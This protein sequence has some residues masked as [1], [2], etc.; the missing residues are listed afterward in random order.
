M[1]L[2]SHNVETITETVFVPVPSYGS[3]G[4]LWDNAGYL[5]EVKNVSSTRAWTVEVTEL[6]R[7]MRDMADNCSEPERLKGINMCVGLAKQLLVLS[8]LAKAGIENVEAKRHA[9]ELSRA[10]I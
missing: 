2:L 4:E 1:G 6:I 3:H 8:Q 5:S 9:E 7:L 10:G